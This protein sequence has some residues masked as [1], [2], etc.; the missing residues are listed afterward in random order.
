[1]KSLVELHG[2][3]VRALSDGQGTGSTFVVLLPEA[4]PKVCKNYADAFDVPGTFGAEP[5]WTVTAML[6]A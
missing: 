5:T 2:G 3:T 1:V 4:R 6:D